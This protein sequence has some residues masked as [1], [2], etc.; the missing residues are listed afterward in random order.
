MKQLL[1][2]DDDEANR[3]TLSTLLEDDGF[4]VD[5]AASHEGVGREL[6]GAFRAAVGRADTGGAVF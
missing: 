2:V 4:T 1:L 3:L 5:L 6:F